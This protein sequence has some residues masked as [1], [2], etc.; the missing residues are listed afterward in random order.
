MAPTTTLR[1]PEA[2][3]RKS[4]MPFNQKHEAQF[5]VEV[6]SR[7]AATGAVTSCVCRFCD[8][9]GR[10]VSEERTEQSKRRKTTKIQYFGTL[11]PTST[12]GT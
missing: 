2:K 1:P 5:G 6:A 11:E 12:P 8:V 9:F 4:M 7:D 10:E 3:S